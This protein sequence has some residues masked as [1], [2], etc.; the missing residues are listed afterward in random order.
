MERYWP[1]R[2]DRFARAV[3]RLDFILEPLRRRNRTEVTARIDINWNTKRRRG[4]E[5]ASDKC[6]ALHC[7]VTDA[8]SVGFIRSCCFCAS[9]AATRVTDVDIAA[10]IYD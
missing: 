7:R 2:K 5:N 3:H 6:R 4:S 8:D 10:T 9:V 1:Q